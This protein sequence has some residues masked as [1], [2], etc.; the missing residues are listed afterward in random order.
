[1]VGDCQRGPAAEKDDCLSKPIRLPELEAVPERWKAVIQDRCGT[2]DARQIS[3]EDPAKNLASLIGY[4]HRT[5]T[6]IAIKPDITPVARN[7]LLWRSSG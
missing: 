6:Q 7:I 2:Q 3:G 1:M 5:A 4:F